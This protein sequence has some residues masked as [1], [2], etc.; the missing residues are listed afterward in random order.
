M[1]KFIVA[2][3]ILIVIGA[4][5]CGVGCAIVF[6]KYDGAFGK[7]IN[8]TE[9]VFDSEQAFTTVSFNLKYAH[10]ISFVRGEK[11]SVK[12]SDAEDF[13]TTVSSQNG[14]L[15]ISESK[16]WSW[17]ENFI[18]KH[19][20]TTDIVIT[21]PD[22]VELSL[23]GH[24]SGASE[25]YLPSWEFGTINLKISGATSFKG[26]GVKTGNLDFDISGASKIELNGE[27]GSV[28]VELSGA[29]KL[30]LSGTAPSLSLHASGSADVDCESFTCPSV[31][32]SAS[33]SVD[34]DLKGT[35]DVLEV[36]SSGSA[37]I[38]AKEFPLRRASFDGSGSMKAEVSVSEYLFVKASGSSTIKYW[39]DP[40]V[41]R[42]TS[43]SSTVKKMG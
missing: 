14:T 36:K 41:D 20:T 19:L 31:T 12:Y 17:W 26:Y 22:E 27:L 7:E 18:F 3:I 2:M 43:G 25:V 29:T 34:I 23:G 42:E 13:P 39:G 38:D 21:V 35:G 16:N 4:I 32:V 30:D 24:F 8:Y 37:E 5:I 40:T 15:T 11:Y 28:K 10:K 9:H 6:T 1:R 33:G